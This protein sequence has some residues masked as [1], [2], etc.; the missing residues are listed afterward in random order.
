MPAGRIILS[1][2]TSWSDLHWSA[3]I[4]TLSVQAS[5]QVLIDALWAWVIWY[6]R[7]NLSITTL[8]QEGSSCPAQPHDLIYTDLQEYII[9]VSGIITKSSFN[10]L[11]AQVIWYLM[12]NLSL[13]PTQ[14]WRIHAPLPK[15]HDPIYTHIPFSEGSAILSSP[16]LIDCQLGFLDYIS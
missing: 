16:Q 3:G 9:Q 2:S 15:P 5:Y 4:H 1:C 8:T 11:W 10:C 14:A 7:C 6:L 13:T 12:Y